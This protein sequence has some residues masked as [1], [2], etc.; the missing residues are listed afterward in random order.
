MKHKHNISGHLMI[1]PC[2]VIYLFFV[3]LPVLMT[4]WFS[5]RDYDLFSQS[6]FVGIDNF[7]R[8][9][10]DPLFL[11]SVKNTFVYALGTIVPQI[12]LG[13]LLAV[14]LNTNVPGKGFF[15]LAFYIPYLVSM[16]SVA[17][18]WLWIYDPASGVLNRFVKL[19]GLPPQRWL[20]DMKLALSS[21]MVMGIWKM[22]GYNMIIYLAGLQQIPTQLY[23]AA[24]ID[25]INSFRK[26]LHITVPLIQPTT[27]FLIVIN[28]IQSF[29]VFEQVNIMT[30]GGPSNATTTIVHQMY[31]R[32]FVDFQMGYASSMGVFLLLITI[33]LTIFNFKYGREGQDLS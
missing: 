11:V 17:M 33:L 8:L 9:V 16:V 10:K 22:S 20:F 31:E 12:V 2:Y 18:L 23:E 19:I 7:I 4:V 30:D 21:L 1:L 14:L 15:R 6:N 29:A 5:F 28:T 25:G 27:F 26:F 3:L 24:D 32:G 13:L